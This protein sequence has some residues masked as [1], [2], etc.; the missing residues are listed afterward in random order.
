MTISLPGL[1]QR[2]LYGR[3]GGDTETRTWRVVRTALT[4]GAG[5]RSAECVLRAQRAQM[6]REQDYLVR[7]TLPRI[8]KEMVGL[9]AIIHRKGISRV[10]CGVVCFVSCVHKWL[11]N[12]IISCA[13]NCT[14]EDESNRI[15]SRVLC[16]VIYRIILGPWNWQNCVV[17]YCVTETWFHFQTDG[18]AITLP[19]SLLRVI[20]ATFLLQPQ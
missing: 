6:T 3:V 8:M 1:Y 14:P 17:V 4:A 11:A 19:L 20:H 16:E 18:N 13:S 9:R 15:V 5:Q 2:L 12:E 10:L 7:Q